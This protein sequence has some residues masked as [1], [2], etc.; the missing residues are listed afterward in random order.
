MHHT[1]NLHTYTYTE[2]IIHLPAPFSLSEPSWTQFNLIVKLDTAEESPS[3]TTFQNKSK[4][5]FFKN[6]YSY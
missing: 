6:V 4:N 5:S 1:L 2:V 3:W